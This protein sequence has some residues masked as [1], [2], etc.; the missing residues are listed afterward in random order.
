VSVPASLIERLGDEERAFE[1]FTGFSRCHI[2][3]Y[4]NDLEEYDEGHSGPLDTQILHQT[5]LA[6][7]GTCALCQ[8]L[9]KEKRRDQESPDQC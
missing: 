1:H 9:I 6:H 8:N 5:R 4:G 7:Y 2:I 3:H